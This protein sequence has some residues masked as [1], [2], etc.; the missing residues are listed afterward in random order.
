MNK[1]NSENS[2][3]IL[4]TLRILSTEFSYRLFNTLLKCKILLDLSFTNLST[5]PIRKKLRKQISSERKEYKI[6]IIA[7][8][9]SLNIQLIH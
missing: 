7:Y 1:F 4:L 2:S 9:F 5:F 3:T 8:I 6:S